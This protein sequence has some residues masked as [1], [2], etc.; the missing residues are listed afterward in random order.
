MSLEADLVIIT[1]GSG[2]SVA[3]MGEG[4]AFPVLVS[5]DEMM[6]RQTAFTKVETED[7][8]MKAVTSGARMRFRPA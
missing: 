5:E 3:I 6:Q 1:G 4:H 8:N 7:E 2:R